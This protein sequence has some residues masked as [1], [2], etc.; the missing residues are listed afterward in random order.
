MRKT[1]EIGFEEE[2]VR[3]FKRKKAINVSQEE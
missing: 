3:F 1:L 2:E